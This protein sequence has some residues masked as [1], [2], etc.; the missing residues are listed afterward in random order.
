MPSTSS[1]DINIGTRIVFL[2]A[3]P[4]PQRQ[5]PPGTARLGLRFAT[6]SDPPTP[7]EIEYLTKQI[8]DQILR[9]LSDPEFD[10]EL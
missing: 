8:I 4:V 10:R 9:G 7:A 6:T 3:H 1:T 5:P 2:P